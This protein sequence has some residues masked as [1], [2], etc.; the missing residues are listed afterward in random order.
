VLKRLAIPTDTAQSAAAFTAQ[1]AAVVNTLKA[2]FKGKNIALGVGIPGDTDH[3]KGILRWAPNIPWH[4]FRIKAALE[5]ATGCRCFVS[6]DANMA[7][8][9]VHAKELKYKYQN[10][11]VVTMGTGIG[12]GIIIGGRLHNGAT[13]SSGELGHAKIDFGPRAP[14]CGCGNRGCVEAYCGAAGIRRAALAAARKNPRSVLAG[15]VK[16]EGFCAEILSAAARAGDKTALGLWRD[17][18]LRLGQGLANMILLLNPQAVVLAGGVS[19]GAGYFE[20][21]IREVFAAQSVKTPFEN[22]KLLVSRSE[23]IGAAG[24]AL[25]A[26]AGADE[27]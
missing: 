7:A 24:A 16:K 10:L 1:L 19:R 26:A 22:V 11:V 2:G 27:K 12:C 20:G 13:G 14:L 8:W 21:A 3:Q 5:A 15:L 17:I 18:G 25:Y 9:G 23:D 6:N 4:G